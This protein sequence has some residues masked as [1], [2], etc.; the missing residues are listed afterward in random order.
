M[1]EA[2]FGAEIMAKHDMICLMVVI[3]HLGDGQM[4]NTGTLIYAQ[5]S[6]W[7]MRGK[8]NS[9]RKVKER[10]TDPLQA[11]RG[12]KVEYTGTVY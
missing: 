11:L 6:N 10:K 2:Q 3:I 4:A 5:R 8:H 7:W 9:C 12:N 1:T